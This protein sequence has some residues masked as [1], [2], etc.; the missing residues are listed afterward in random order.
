MALSA[1][2]SVESSWGHGFIKATKRSLSSSVRRLDRSNGDLHSHIVDLL[3][4]A[5]LTATQGSGLTW[6]P[7]QLTAEWMHDWTKASR[8]TYA[9]TPRKHYC[10]MTD[11]TNAHVASCTCRI[12]WMTH[13]DTCPL[14]L[15]HPV[16]GSLESLRLS[17]DVMIVECFTKN[18]HAA[19]C[20]WYKHKTHTNVWW[21]WVSHVPLRCRLT[22]QQR[23]RSILE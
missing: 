1:S 3:L 2:G 18:G 10:E 16:T 7:L 17:S 21:F 15:R 22:L 20:E 13:T 23:L 9:C 19:L 4:G 11:N 8:S 14:V 6:K 12:V 5:A